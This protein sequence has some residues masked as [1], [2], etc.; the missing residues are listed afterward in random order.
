MIISITPSKKNKIKIYADGEF[1]FTVESVIW[2]SS[3]FRGGDI[4]TSEELAE[5]KRKS[6]LHEAFESGLRMLSLRA[7]SKYELKVKLR[8]K[9]SEDAVQEALERLEDTGLIDDE[10]F[11]SLLAAELYE[12]KRFA[13]PRILSE[14]KNRGLSSEIAQNAVN[15]L[16]IDAEI[17]IIKVIEK[18]GLTSDSSPKEKS[19]IIRRLL[20]M[21]Y[22]Y[23]EISKYIYM[24]QD[25]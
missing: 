22:S 14:L 16:D 18:A 1:Q 23:P 2:Y 25:T 9:Y 12:K 13:P 3:R 10:K 20:S 4:V 5:L 17:G 7:H 21:G 19:R 6:E 15:S 24:E 11:A 8:H